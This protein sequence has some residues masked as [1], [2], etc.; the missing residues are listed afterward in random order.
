L[1]GIHILPEVERAVTAG[2]HE[3]IS[4]LRQVSPAPDCR[5]VRL[6]RIE[7][8]YAWIRMYGRMDV[9]LCFIDLHVCLCENMCINEQ[10]DSIYSG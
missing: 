1:G 2:C 6:Q 8:G 9:G 4:V 5:L 10:T 7:C 3:H